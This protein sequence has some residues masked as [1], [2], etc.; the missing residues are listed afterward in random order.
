MFI[1]PENKRTHD[2][3]KWWSAIH[4]R[5]ED[6]TITFSSITGGLANSVGNQPQG[7]S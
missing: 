5:V 1:D 7:N 4:K 3:K 2:L 6:G